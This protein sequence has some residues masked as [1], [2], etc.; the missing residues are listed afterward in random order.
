M[1]LVY[2][3]SPQKRMKRDKINNKSFNFISGTLVFVGQDT[4]DFKG[5]IIPLDECELPK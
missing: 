1:F 5:Q 3:I 4:S 2:C